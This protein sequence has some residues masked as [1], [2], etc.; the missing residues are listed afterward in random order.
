MDK[1]AR[2]GAASGIAAVI[3]F[4][5]G[6]FIVPEPPNPDASAGE[7]ASYFAEEDTAIQVGAA[8][9]AASALLLLWFLA[10]LTAVTR[11]TEGGPRL[12]STAFGAGVIAI[13]LLLADV[14]AF[15][16][17]AFRP[18]N[19]QASPELAQALLDFSVLALGVGSVVFAGLFLAMGLLSLRLQALPAW[20]GWT[21]LLVAIL[22]ALRLGSIF[23]TEGVFGPDGVL[24]FWAGLIGFA[25]W[26][27]AASITLVESLWRPDGGGI[28]GRVRGAVTG[29]ASG[30][31]AGASGRRNT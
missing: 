1:W 11:I 27:L 25:A 12:S 3:L 16:V 13:A 9:V 10:T 14:T 26:T 5:I 19:M 7:V 20:L 21:A 28:T 31:A 30:A 23:T 4:G 29:A 6:F 2:Y 15:A 17:G 8:F 22:T 24:G 18:E